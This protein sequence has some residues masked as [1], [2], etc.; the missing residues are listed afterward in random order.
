[1]AHG[2]DAWRAH[3]QYG[4]HLVGAKQ[5]HTCMAA[6]Q[7]H[8]RRLTDGEATH[9]TIPCTV[10]RAPCTIHRLPSLIPHAPPHIMRHHA[11]CAVHHAV[12]T[13]QRAPTA[14][15]HHAH[16]R[17]CSQ[18]HHGGALARRAGQ[19]TPG[20]RGRGAG[21]GAADEN[22]A[23]GRSLANGSAN[24]T[25]TSGRNGAPDAVADMGGM[26]GEADQRHRASGQGGGGRG[27]QA[28]G[29][30][31]GGSGDGTGGGRA[32]HG[33]RGGRGGGQPGRGGG[34]GRGHGRGN[35]RGGNSGEHAAAVA[36]RELRG[37]DSDEDVDVMAMVAAVSKRDAA[38][39]E[40]LEASGATA[41]H[42]TDAG[43]VDFDGEDG[44]GEGGGGRRRR[45]AAAGE[46]PSRGSGDGEHGGGGDGGGAGSG[47]APAPKRK[48]I[49]AAGG[50]AEGSNPATAGTAPAPKH[51]PG[52]L[53][54]RDTQPGADAGAVF[55]G[56]P[57]SWASMGVDE[58]LVQQ[59]SACKFEKPTAV[60]K[61]AI[62]LLMVWTLL[63]RV[64]CVRGVPHC[65]VPGGA[66]TLSCSF[67][68]TMAFA[69]LSTV[70]LVK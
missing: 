67:V 49:A 45:F 57:G 30:G 9:Q 4:G 28:A 7:Q 63:L 12:C 61:D 24:G 50:Q 5:W 6:V 20:P 31:R 2:G 54:T 21:R 33:S 25:S 60:Q 10:H 69:W 39:Q 65:T 70:G 37:A 13:T 19:Q 14:H 48:R 42:G 41:R 53:A 32:G 40:V 52:R 16:M 26:Y 62:P 35:G 38:L 23:R 18:R 68:S 29:A 59:L 51:V 44:G 27:Q 3:M 8:K 22:T 58:R 1:M 56:E 11:P 34:R 43:V 64:M 46:R 36:E 17:V 55:G 66:A 15:H 47:G